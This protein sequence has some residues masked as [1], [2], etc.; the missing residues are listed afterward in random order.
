[1]KIQNKT[2]S[3]TFFIDPLFQITFHVI[4]PMPPLILVYNF[5]AKDSLPYF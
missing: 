3:S 2:S 5:I 1:M 4:S